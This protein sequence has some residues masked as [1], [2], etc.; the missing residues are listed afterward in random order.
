MSDRIYGISEGMIQAQRF[1]NF[2]L[3][4]A[5]IV[6]VILTTMFNLPNIFLDL[7]TKFILVWLILYWYGPDF[8]YKFAFKTNDFAAW[9]AW[10]MNLHEDRRWR[11]TPPDLV[12]TQH[13]DGSIDVIGE[14]VTMRN[15]TAGGSITVKARRIK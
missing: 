8:R 11:E 14:N 1:H 3:T 4:H 7:G 5:F 10:Q 12:V 2:L 15:V 6:F 9:L 13:S